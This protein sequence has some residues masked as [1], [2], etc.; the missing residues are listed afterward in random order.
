MEK[1]LQNAP[2]EREH[3][4]MELLAC[5]KRLLVLGTFFV[6]F[7]WLLMTGF[8]VLLSQT[9]FDCPKA[10]QDIEVLL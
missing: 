10:V 6:F 9:N 8:T 5:I 7:E 2:R 1:V 4:A 3:C